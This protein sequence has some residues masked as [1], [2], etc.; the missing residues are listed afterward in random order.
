MSMTRGLRASPA[1]GLPPIVARVLLPHERRVVT[2][3]YHPAVL[4]VPSLAAFGGLI[5]AAV[6]SFLNL[7]ADAL[8]IV[9]SFWGLALLYWLLSIARYRV[10]LFVVTSQRLLLITGFVTRDIQTVPLIKALQLGL[11]RSFMGRLLGYG[12]FVLDGADARYGIR[13]VNFL[14][15]PEQLYLE[16]MGLIFKDPDDE[17]T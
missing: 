6:L 13:N 4:F 15:Y 14:P 10:A 16:V 7:G 9:W 12:R 2:V 8:A 11:R 1:D 5:A 17:S 3:R